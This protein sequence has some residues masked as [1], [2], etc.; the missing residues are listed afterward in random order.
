MG[1][2]MLTKIAQ[3]L[4]I[5]FMCFYSTQTPSSSTG[6]P[7]PYQ[8]TYFAIVF[9]V[10]HLLVIE[11]LFNTLSQSVSV[12]KII[13]IVSQVILIY[14]GF[15]IVSMVDRYF[16]QGILW[17]ALSAGNISVTIIACVWIC[18][19]V[20]ALRILFSIIKSRGL[21]SK[22]NKKIQWFCINIKYCIG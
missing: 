5:T 14:I 21:K 17:S 20:P 4:F 11:K 1:L 22:E 8:Y 19:T 18:L 15:I 9:T 13:I 2:V 6:T 10:V 7:H 16:Y 12:Y 3:G